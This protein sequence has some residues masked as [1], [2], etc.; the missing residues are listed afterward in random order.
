MIPHL[1]ASD[2]RP[3][4]RNNQTRMLH[5]FT[6]THM[7]SHLLSRPSSYSPAFSSLVNT[8]SKPGQP[9]DRRWL[10]SIF[11]Y[12]LKSCLITRLSVRSH[13]CGSAPVE[14]PLQTAGV[15]SPLLNESSAVCAFR[16]FGRQKEN[17]LYICGIATFFLNSVKTWWASSM[18]LDRPTSWFL[19]KGNSLHLRMWTHKA[20]TRPNGKLI[21]IP[22]GCKKKKKLIT[23]DVL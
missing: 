16:G 19:A 7:A 3:A 22:N 4:M 18:W 5:T 6:A 13:V 21:P 10:S 11:V 8:Q 17:C 2:G 14:S 23:V 15:W 12:V 1:S 9:A 20:R